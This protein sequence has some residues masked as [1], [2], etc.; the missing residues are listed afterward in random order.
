MGEGIVSLFN[1]HG[2][3]NNYMAPLGLRPRTFC[4]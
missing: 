3:A 1:P 4:M 2:G